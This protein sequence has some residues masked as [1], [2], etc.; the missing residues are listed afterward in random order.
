MIPFLSLVGGVAFIVIALASLTTNLQ[1]R[2][3]LTT[4]NVGVAAAVLL[5]ALGDLAND[6]F[7]ALIWAL[8][9]LPIALAAARLARRAADGTSTVRKRE[10]VA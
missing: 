5:N 2:A 10:E 9:N 1:R 3:T 4:I 7:I 6:W 8:A